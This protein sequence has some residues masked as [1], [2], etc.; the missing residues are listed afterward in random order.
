MA[1]LLGDFY[2]EWALDILSNHGYLSLNP[3]PEKIVNT[4]WSVV[5]RFATHRG[6]IYLKKVPPPLFLEV[7]IIK[8]L[9]T[10]FKAKVPHLIADNPEHHC[11]LMQ[12]AGIPLHDVLKENFNLEWLM[13]ALQD[14]TAL[15][16]KTSDRI[17]FLIAEG[18]PD[19]RLEKLPQRYRSLLNEEKLLLA[20]GLSHVE[21]EKL[22]GL[23]EKLLSICEQL[24][25]YS[26]P[27]TLSHCDFHDKN[28][29]IDTQTHQTTL[30]D[31]G[32]VS[33]T[34]PFFSILNYLHR[35]Q[36]NFQISEKQH[37]FIQE[38]ALEPWLSFESKDRMLEIL[39]LIQQCWSIHAVLGE[40]HL[41]QSVAPLHRKTLSTQGRFANK[42]RA[43]MGEK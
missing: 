11:F 7:L 9:A 12:D 37:H 17:D 38:M 3:I 24:S 35:A 41:I 18:L 25:Q 15:Q 28:I 16:L 23:E 27:E 31:L 8:I 29:L 26:I 2:T 34:H 21:I 4:A 19:W 14:Y 43:W 39:N 30:I 32:E 33:I 6:A 1:K 10:Q 22:R 36:E 5:Y 13:Q 20:D 42:L 40:Y